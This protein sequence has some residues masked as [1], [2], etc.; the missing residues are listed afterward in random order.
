MPRAENLTG[1]RDKTY[2][3]LAAFLEQ[4]PPERA[5]RYA[6]AVLEGLREALPREGNRA[7]DSILVAMQT[8]LGWRSASIDGIVLKK[9]PTRSP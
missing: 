9:V 7:R 5:E 3:W 1:H 6:G 8:V 2:K 4:L